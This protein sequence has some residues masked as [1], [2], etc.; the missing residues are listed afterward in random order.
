MFFLS[1]VCTTLNVEKNNQRMNSVLYLYEIHSS[2]F[3]T[4]PKNYGLMFASLKSTVTK[5]VIVCFYNFGEENF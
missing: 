1:T 5:K 2:Y 3:C 4:T